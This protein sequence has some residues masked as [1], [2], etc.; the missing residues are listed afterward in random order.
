VAASCTLSGTPLC[1]VLSAMYLSKSNATGLYPDYCFHDNADY[2]VDQQKKGGAGCCQTPP[3]YS[4]PACRCI[5]ITLPTS[6][7]NS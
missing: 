7:T 6:H 5:D 4:C 1:L 3:V 2:G